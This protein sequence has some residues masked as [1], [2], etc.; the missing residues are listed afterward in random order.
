MAVEGDAHRYEAVEGLRAVAALLVLITHVAYWTGYVNSGF[1]GG[2]ASRGDLGVAVFFVLSGFLLTKPWLD[3]A[4]SGRSSPSIRRYAVHR[5]ARLL[6][7][8]YLALAAVLVTAG[9]TDPIDD[10]DP[11]V[12]AGSVVAHGLLAQGYVGP[13]FSTF[14]QTWSLTTEVTFY[15]LLPVLAG[16][17]AGAVRR[18][19]PR[20][21]LVRVALSCA[22][23]VA[24]GLIVTGLAG[25]EVLP[26]SDKVALSAL[27]HSAWFATGV[28][29]ACLTSA[30]RA[31]QPPVPHHPAI[32]LIRSS[33]NLLMATAGILLL[34]A[35]TPIAGP[36]GFAEVPTANAVVK[37]L[38]YA[39]IAATALLATLSRDEHGFFRVL[40][41]PAMR[42][43]GRISYGI[44]LWHLVVIQWWYSWSDWRI[45]AGHFWTVLVIALAGSVFV[46]TLSY[47]FLE[48]PL[49]SRARR[50]QGP[51]KHGDHGQTEQLRE[52][53]AEL[54][55]VDPVEGKEQGAGHQQEREHNPG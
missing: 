3:A 35:I 47:L 20:G 51:G 41:T 36:R 12:D 8:Y 21:G 37:E 29:V 19:G 4:F 30:D 31:D 44:F 14:S 40:A 13:L 55:P 38:L 32:Q 23:V 54:V 6:P 22:A 16:L 9:L 46:A 2:V 26:E 10:T 34:V 48:R 43:L 53:S 15:L 18:H 28:A 27:G 42:F 39:L 50:Y 52:V 24:I 7:A 45:F 33:P 1:M 17:A 5:A 49:M 11:S 25:A